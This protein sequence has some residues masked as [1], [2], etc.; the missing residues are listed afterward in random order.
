ME[1]DCLRRLVSLTR[2]EGFPDEIEV[3]NLIR[4]GREV[5]AYTRELHA[6]LE[7]RT[8]PPTDE[9]IRAHADAGGAWLVTLPAVK[10]VREKSETRYTDSPREISRLWWCGGARWVSVMDGRP[11]AWPV[12]SG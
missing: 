9:E 12:V 7:G 8:T 5:I 3:N 2:E 6:I 11:C 10:Q 4:T 1:P